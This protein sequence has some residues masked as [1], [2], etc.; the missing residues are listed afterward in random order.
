[1]VGARTFRQRAESGLWGLIFNRYYRA[2]IIGV[3]SDMAYPKQ[4][5]RAIAHVYTFIDGTVEIEVV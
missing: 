2:L 5:K 3:M 1:M 4:T